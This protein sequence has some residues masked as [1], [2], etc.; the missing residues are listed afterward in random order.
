MLSE[1]LTITKYLDLIP[2]YKI[3]TVNVQ[4]DTTWGFGIV[5]GLLEDF[6]RPWLNVGVGVS[7]VGRWFFLDGGLARFGHVVWQLSINVIALSQINHISEKK[8]I[9]K[10][11]K[12]LIYTKGPDSAYNEC[13][14]Y[15]W[16]TKSS[17]FPALMISI[18]ASGWLRYCAGVFPILIIP[19]PTRN[20][21][22]YAIL[23][24]FTC[25]K[26]TRL[27]C[28]QKSCWV[29][30]EEQKNFLAKMFRFIKDVNTNCNIADWMIKKRGFS[31]MFLQSLISQS[32]RKDTDL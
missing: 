4:S 18:L 26:N 30:F 19:S 13:H 22:L 23:L 28:K 6:E 24:G 3:Y 25:K 10:I 12:H 27:Y 7:T 31:E 16:T 5:E 20:P 15:L 14:I 21:L 1:S 8:N 2:T 9:I 29:I 17:S 11:H 32:V